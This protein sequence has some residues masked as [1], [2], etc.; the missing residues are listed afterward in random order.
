VITPGDS[1][2]S[3]GVLTDSGAFKQNT[4]GSLDISIGGA[5]PGSK[6][7]Q[8]NSSTANLAGTMNIKLINGFIPALGANFKVLNFSSE[9]GK[10]A[11]VNGLAINGSEHFA[12]TYQGTDVLLTVIG[13]PASAS[14]TV[15]PSR[16]SGGQLQSLR[17]DLQPV[18]AS[19]RLRALPPATM[20][21]SSLMW[22]SAGLR[23]ADIS[24][25]PQTSAGARLGLSL[26][27]ASAR[28]F[29]P[30]DAAGARP[31]A[32]GHGRIGKGASGTM[33]FS[34]LKPLSMPV[35]FF[36]VE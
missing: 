24:S 1:A 25:L 10:F 12:V 20:E 14:T 35:F 23:L 32:S 8:L 21:R 11:T 9:T 19:L 17:L 5:T 29:S 28:G 26:P 7:D 18:L 3:T 22:A 30:V 6:F 16:A 34:L 31:R 4:G 13:G 15:T 33:Q 2:I 27:A 36:A